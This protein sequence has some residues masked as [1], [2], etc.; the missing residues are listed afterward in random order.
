M[1]AVVFELATNETVSIAIFYL[2]A[3]FGTD[4][5][6]EH[7]LESGCINSFHAAGL[8]IEAAICISEAIPRNLFFGRVRHGDMWD[9]ITVTDE[10]AI[11]ESD[12]GAGEVGF[13]VEGLGVL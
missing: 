9:L 3:S 11:C 7:A 4:I 5:W 1:H 6:Q 8:G 12:F 2:S 10:L 13:Y